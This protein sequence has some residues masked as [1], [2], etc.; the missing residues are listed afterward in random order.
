MIGYTLGATIMMQLGSFQFSVN[1]AAYQELK[2]RSEYRWPKQDLYG[3]RPGRQFT[4]PGDESM[5]ITGTIFTEYRGGLGQIEQMRAQAGR[6][7]PLL[8]VNGYGGLMGRWVIESI[9]EG[10]KVFAAFGRPRK[11]D[12]AL[13]LARF[14]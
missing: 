13:Q 7:Q 14:S 1:T 6:G 4:G 11:Q 3:R 10:Q 8:L 5:T 9:E 2:R 12:F